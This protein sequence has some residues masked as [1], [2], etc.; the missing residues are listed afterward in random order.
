MAILYLLLQGDSH[1]RLIPE[2]AAVISSH[3]TWTKGK[4]FLLVPYHLIAAK[5][6]ESA[7]LGGYAEYIHRHFPNAPT[8]AIYR[9]EGL[10]ANAAPLR[11]T[12]GDEK[13]FRKLTKAT[14]GNSGDGTG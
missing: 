10:L 14:K 11:E 5:N 2:L 8:P 3:N 13:F 12:M 4:K 9:S 7:I 1:A 6:L